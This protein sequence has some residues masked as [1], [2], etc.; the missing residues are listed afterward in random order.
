MQQFVQQ[1]LDRHG[2]DLLGKGAQDII[3][4][5]EEQD[6][7]KGKGGQ[8]NVHAQVPVFRNARIGEEQYK[9]GNQHQRNKGFSES[10][11]CDDHVSPGPD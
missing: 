8:G 4:C 6:E 1:F 7:D 9:R 5:F 3:T 10:H 11:G 2:G